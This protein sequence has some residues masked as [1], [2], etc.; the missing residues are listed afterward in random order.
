MDPG[1][2]RQSGSSQILSCNG[3]RSGGRQDAADKSPE[4]KDLLAEET[5]DGMCCDV[6]VT[7]C[8]TVV[9][10]TEI[11]LDAFLTVDTYC[12]ELSISR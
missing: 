3:L 5:Y 12:I 10:A 11:M 6:T 1:Y 4:E 9:V 7:V 2:V 8:V